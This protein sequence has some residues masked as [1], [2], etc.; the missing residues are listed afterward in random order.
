MNTSEL[1]FRR[2]LNGRTKSILDFEEGRSSSYWKLVN[3]FHKQL[4][5]LRLGW[6]IRAEM[7]NTQVPPDFD[8]TWFPYFVNFYPDIGD[9]IYNYKQ[10]KNQSQSQIHFTVPSCSVLIKK[11]RDDILV[12][13]ATWHVY[14][15]MSY[16]VLKR[17]NLNYH[18]VSG[19]LVHSQV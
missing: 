5:G 15:S 2:T 17:Y 12:G 19:Y 18:T 16:R 14:T 1:S 13:H 10:F 7:E 6:L 3:L 8:V 9:Y 4:E 11:T